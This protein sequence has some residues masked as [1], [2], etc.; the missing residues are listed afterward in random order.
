MN[1]ECHRLASTGFDNG[2]LEIVWQD[3]TNSNFHP[4]WLRDNCR[5]EICGDPAIGYRNLRLTQLELDCK[6]GTIETT[7]TMLSVVWDD[8]HRSQYPGSWLRCH[9]Y[10]DALRAARV[11]APRLWDRRFRSNPPGCEYADAVGNDAALLQVLQRVRDHGICFLRNAPAEPGIVEALARRFGF[12][13][14]SNFGRVQDLRFDPGKRSIAND[15]KALKPHTDEPYRASPP[16]LLLFHCIANDQRGAGSSLFMDGFELAIKLRQHD[17]EGFAALC[18]HNHTFRRH[19]VGDVD[20]ISEFPVISIDEFGNPCGVRVNDRVAAPLSIPAGQIEVYYRGLRYLLG[21]AENE[22]LMLR[23]TLQPGDIAIFDNHRV[24]HGRSD[25]TINGQRW[26]QW[27]QV[28]RG[29]FHSSLRIFAD[30]LGIER[31]ANPLLRGAYGS[32][33]QT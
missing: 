16:G 21:L 28:E 20:L 26:L 14:E 10:D 4:I 12:P 17:A 23:Q 19:F 18:R 9:A 11:F 30:R 24:L 27:V 13:Q 25:L 7:S 8:G 1:D 32:A 29:D 2:M 22:S 15:V 33:L 31:D 3:G 5:C 6:P